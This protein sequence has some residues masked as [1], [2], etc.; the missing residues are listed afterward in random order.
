MA[1]EKSAEVVHAT[2]FDVTITRAALLSLLDGTAGAL[3]DQ[4]GMPMLSNVRLTAQGDELRACT[5]D[6][7]LRID[8]A[9][10]ATVRVG[11]SIAIGHKLLRK[12]IA[13]YPEGEIRL[14][15]ALGGLQILAPRRRSTLPTAPGIDFPEPP[16]FTAPMAVK[17]P[18]PR[19]RAFLGRIGPLRADDPL[20]AISGVLVESTSKGV[21]MVASEGH[22]LMKDV[23]VFEGLPTFKVVFPGVLVAE[24]LRTLAG[25]EGEVT[26][27]LSATSERCRLLVGRQEITSPLMAMAFP[28]W[29][30]V[31]PNRQDGTYSVARAELIA[32]L[33]GLVTVSGRTGE[34][35]FE[36]DSMASELK[37]SA[38]QDGG[39]QETRIVAEVTGKPPKIGTCRDQLVT[40][41][42]AIACD[43]V[44][45]GMGGEMDPISI[46]AEGQPEFAGITMPMRVS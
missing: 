38:E 19:F 46:T 9:A 7:T 20:R 10:T 32:A 22:S 43:Q 25:V 17:V 42:N 45:L 28:A 37:L 31:M 14:S 15:S 41:L 4:R 21:L 5:T 12:V 24:T 27:E 34:V 11:G 16:R 23:E 29:E 13:G 26:F 30:Q 35:T 33:R 6:L 39:Q 8:T 1:K 40:I 44:T 2:T 18:A 3:G 36:F